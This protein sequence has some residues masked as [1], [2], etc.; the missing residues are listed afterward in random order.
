MTAHESPDRAAQEAAQAATLTAVE[1]EALLRAWPWPQEAATTRDGFSAVVAAVEALLR[2][3][4]AAYPAGSTSSDA[5]ADAYM[6]GRG[7]YL[8]LAA[9]VEALTD[10]WLA[11]DEFALRHCAGGLRAL[12]PPPPTPDD[13]AEIRAR[14]D[15]LG[16]DAGE[17][18]T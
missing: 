16:A 7:D 4:L 2:D 18:G 9:A 17:A 6:R 10:E 14:A 5:L 12:L 11:S 1:R 15:G 8:R 13:P 3:R